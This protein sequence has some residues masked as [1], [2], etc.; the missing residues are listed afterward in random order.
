MS[1]RKHKKRSFDIFGLFED[2]FLL[3]NNLLSASSS[4]YSI[5]VTYG[6]DGKPLVKVQ[7]QGNVDKDALRSELK[8]KYPDAKIEGLIDE[9]LI[10]EISTETL[11]P[12]S[13][14]GEKRQKKPLIKEE[15]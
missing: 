8:R 7:T 2:N 9:P 10:R 15:E 6:S 1:K 3:D 12:E 11:K 5:S 13:D 14:K 4:G